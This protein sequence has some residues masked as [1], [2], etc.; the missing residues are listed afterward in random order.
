MQIFAAAD[1]AVPFKSHHMWELYYS[2][3]TSHSMQ[4]ARELT[5]DTLKAR[6][7]R[8]PL[9]NLGT[10]SAVKGDDVLRVL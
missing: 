7:T 3:N 4:L 9:A 2:V 8:E 10:S 5:S 6:L 1:P